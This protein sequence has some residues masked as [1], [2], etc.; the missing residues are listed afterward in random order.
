[1]PYTG[2]IPQTRFGIKRPNQW[3]NILDADLVLVNAMTLAQKTMI[4]GGTNPFRPPNRVQETLN[5]ESVRQ[6]V[7]ACAALRQEIQ[8]KYRT[9]DQEKVVVGFPTAGTRAHPFGYEDA[10][11]N[12]NYLQRYQ[13]EWHLTL[14]VN[15]ESRW[16]RVRNYPDHM[17]RI[18]GT[19]ENF[20]R[21]TLDG[22]DDTRP[23][24]DRRAPRRY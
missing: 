5:S 1:M 12:Y 13:N 16:I 6:F 3:A 7:H 24:R 14:W 21:G 11:G 2:Q 23:V 22:P 8:V 20:V 9:H 17:P 4:R 19:A 18:V 15:A 10:Q